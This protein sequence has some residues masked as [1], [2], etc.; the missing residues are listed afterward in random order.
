MILECKLHSGNIYGIYAKDL[1]KPLIWCVCEDV[2]T[3]QRHFSQITPEY[4][5]RVK[6]SIILLRQ[7]RNVTSTSYL[8][9]IRNLVREEHNLNLQDI[10]KTSIVDGFLQGFTSHRRYDTQIAFLK[11]QKMS[12]NPHDKHKKLTLSKIE[13]IFISIDENA[14]SFEKLYSISDMDNNN[15][16]FKHNKSNNYNKPEKVQ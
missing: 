14:P 6:R 3:L 9:S 4:Q 15:Q 2:I 7:Q 5:S 11:T 1:I 16:E 10:D 12:E 8:R 13:A